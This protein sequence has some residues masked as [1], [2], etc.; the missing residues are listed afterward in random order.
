MLRSPAPSQC[1]DSSCTS[2]PSRI[3]TQA[4]NPTTNQLK[5]PAISSVPV[6]FSL[7]PSISLPLPMDPIRNQATG[8]PNASRSLRSTCRCW[9]T[10]MVDSATRQSA[11]EAM[12][13]VLTRVFF[14]GLQSAAVRE[15]GGAIAVRT[16]GELF[17]WDSNRVCW[18]DSSHPGRTCSALGCPSL[19]VAGA[20]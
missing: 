13:H 10:A 1:S 19:P 11:T 17:K 12:H 5:V 16:T 4:T 20:W 9:V 8:S 6:W 7:P 3:S 14:F 2:S 15:Y 18:F